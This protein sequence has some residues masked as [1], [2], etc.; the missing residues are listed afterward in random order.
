MIL[1]TIITNKAPKNCHLMLL[2]SNDLRGKLLGD[3]RK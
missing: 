3:K 1:T 2:R